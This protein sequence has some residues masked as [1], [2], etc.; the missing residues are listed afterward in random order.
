MSDPWRDDRREVAETAR[1]MEELGLSTSVS[2][3][4][5][6]RLGTSDSRELFAITP[7]GVPYGS[8]GVE[9]VVVVD[10]EVEPVQGTLPPSSESLMHI[11]IYEA[12]PDVGAVIH[13]HGVF[14]S[15]AAVAGL[16]IPPIIDE[17]VVTIGGAIEV[18]EYAFPSSEELARNVQE[19]L[20]DR[21][22]VI[23]S[24]H[25][26]V[27]VGRDLGEALEVSRLA[28]RVAQIFVYASLL[29]EVRTIPEDAVAA[30]AAIFAMRGPGHPAN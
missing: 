9:D 30:E 12:R 10:L 11:A 29:G 14:G 8:L 21:N 19:A 6:K 26:A 18:A 2:G 16:R 5:S 22:A 25:G 7:T 28:E 15:V 3:N 20:K 24:N 27:G 13:T 23:L 1:R 4:V 17:M